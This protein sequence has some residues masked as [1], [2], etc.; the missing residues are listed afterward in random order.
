MCNEMR[1][2]YD[3]EKQEPF[4]T[5]QNS[6]VIGDIVEAAV[7]IIGEVVEAVIDAVT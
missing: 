6:S 1:N 7:E 2:P 4:R 3:A 5:E